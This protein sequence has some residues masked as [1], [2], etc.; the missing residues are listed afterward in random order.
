METMKN[1]NGL[2]NSIAKKIAAFSPVENEFQR[3]HIFFDILNFSKEN[4]TTEQ[5]MDML[6]HFSC[7]EKSLNQARGGNTTLASF[8]LEEADKNELS[9]SKKSEQGMKA[10]YYPMTSF[11]K[12][13]KKDYNSARHEMRKA[14]NCLN[15]LIDNGLSVAYL[16]KIEQSLNIFRITIAM[17]DNAE[18]I[19]Y[20]SCILSYVNSA[21][22][23]EILNGELRVAFENNLEEWNSVIENYTN[24][25][26][27]KLLTVQKNDIG[28]N[29]DLETVIRK[30]NN[31]TNWKN[32]KIPE[33]KNIYEI[34]CALYSREG[35]NIIEPLMQKFLE[36]NISNIPHILIY[37]VLELFCSKAIRDQ[38]LSENE[39]LEFE[40]SCRSFY[41]KLT[42]LNVKKLL[43]YSFLNKEVKAA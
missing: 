7:Y 4:A 22:P 13:A 17:N 42:G 5:I 43:E 20:A 2:L 18:A 33:L 28:S 37:F 24:L 30:A 32:A 29:A 35:Y 27:L 25:I 12:Y 15:Y 8:W 14:I 3:H 19:K 36:I 31:L 23:N 10:L 16:A 39:I 26:L 11:L 1:V 21:E 9:L 41:D 38:D 40:L 34:L 6:F